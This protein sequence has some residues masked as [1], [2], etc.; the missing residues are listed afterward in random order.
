MAG[1]ARRLRN[2]QDAWGA[3]LGEQYRQQKDFI[4]N[5]TMISDNPVSVAD[6]SAVTRV[7]DQEAIACAYRRISERCLI[8]AQ[9]LAV[10]D[11]RDA[12]IGAGSNK[13]MKALTLDLNGRHVIQ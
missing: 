2:K 5:G 10:Q 13:A 4:G 7:I 9:M 11:A 6:N 1:Y 12:G 3:V 8:K